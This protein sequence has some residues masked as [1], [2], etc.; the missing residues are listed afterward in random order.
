MVGTEIENTDK[1]QIFVYFWKSY[2][3]YTYQWKKTVY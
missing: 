1:S 2:A 3:I